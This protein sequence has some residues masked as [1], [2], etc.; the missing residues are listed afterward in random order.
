MVLK[1]L[2]FKM[3][4]TTVLDYLSFSVFEYPPLGENGY[5]EITTLCQSVSVLVSLFLLTFLFL[6]WLIEFFRNFA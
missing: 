1:L 6:K 5:Y 2:Q 3:Q 4:G